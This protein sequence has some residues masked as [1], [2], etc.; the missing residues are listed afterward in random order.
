MRS[1]AAAPPR[2]D[3]T[4]VKRVTASPRA[5][6]TK[7]KTTELSTCPSPQKKEIRRVLERDHFLA[8]LITIKGR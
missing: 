3:S 6:P 1:Q 4:D 7:P 8:L 2:K 5:I